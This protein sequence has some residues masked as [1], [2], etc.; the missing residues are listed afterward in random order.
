[1]QPEQYNEYEAQSALMQDQTE[2]NLGLNSPQLLEQVQQSQAVLVEQT[3][4]KKVIKEIML[5]LRGLEEQPDGKLVRVTEPRMNEAGLEAMWFWFKS[6]VNQGIILSHFDEGQINNF[7]EVIQN[8]LVDELGLNWRIYG[9][10]T[11]TDLDVINN[12]MLM[13]I[14]SALCRAKGQNE[15]NWLG[16]ISIENIRGGERPMPSRR[17]SF[18]SKFKL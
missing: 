10:K 18:W 13:N 12:A 11:K 1:M 3:D 9:I 8:D 14:H 4:P 5:I 17:D 2:G 7:I 6:H 16:R 15:K